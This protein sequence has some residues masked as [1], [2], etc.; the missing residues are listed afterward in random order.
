[1]AAIVPQIVFGEKPSLRQAARVTNVHSH[2]LFQVN[3][4]VAYITSKRI[5]V[6]K[7]NYLKSFIKQMLEHIRSECLEVLLVH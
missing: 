7:K 4:S 5:I 6:S 3:V 1:M 2:I